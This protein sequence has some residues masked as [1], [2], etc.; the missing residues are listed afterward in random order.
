M[1]INHGGG[2][3]LVTEQL[4]ERADVVTGFEQVGGK[5]VTERVR[6]DAFWNGRD[7]GRRLHDALQ[8]VFVDMVT[9]RHAI[10]WITAKI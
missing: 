3:F 6:T 9:A 5:G 1:G 7:T 4:L 8:S 10:P 2:Q